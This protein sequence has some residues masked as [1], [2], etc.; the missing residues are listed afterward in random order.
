LPGSAS[1]VCVGGWWWW[2]VVVESEFSDRFGYSLRLALAKPNKSFVLNET[3]QMSLIMTT[4]LGLSYHIII[5][6]LLLKYHIAS[7]MIF[8][9][10]KISNHIITK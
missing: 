7:V 10:G 6:K 9:P 8:F 3:H 2:V 1:K 4:K 5:D